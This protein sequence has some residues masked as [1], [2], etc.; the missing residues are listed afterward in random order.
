MREGKKDT[1]AGSRKSHSHTANLIFEA[2]S[3]GDI[4]IS[5]IIHLFADKE[6]YL[7]GFSPSLGFPGIKS[8]VIVW[9]NFCVLS[10]TAL[11]LSCFCIVIQ[12]SFQICTV[13]CRK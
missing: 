5:L 8:C 7:L 2:H 6:D 9:L 1:F 4:V 13:D 10:N 11:Q 3:H 12:L